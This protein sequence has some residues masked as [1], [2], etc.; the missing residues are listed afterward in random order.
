MKEASWGDGGVCV[1][2]RVDE[3]RGR[4]ITADEASTT[5]ERT[6]RNGRGNVDGMEAREEKLRPDGVARWSCL[7]T[8]EVNGTSAGE[9][10]AVEAMHKELREKAIVEA[11]DEFP[12]VDAVHEELRAKA[13]MKAAKRLAR[14]A[15]EV[16]ME[17]ERARSRHAEKTRRCAE[18]QQKLER[19][20]SRDARRLRK[21]QDRESRAQLNGKKI[22]PPVERM[23]EP[24][25]LER[26]VV[27]KL[28]GMLA[29]QNAQDDVHAATAAAAAAVSQ[30]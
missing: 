12:V 3:G 16:E 18:K 27:E 6:L 9:S 13:I 19:R 21:L 7:G 17:A 23:G 5:R 30:P 11:A 22:R 24:A 2:I 10:P 28:G 20:A 26:D 14:D 8:G 29:Q 25:R 1:E 4:R 15:V